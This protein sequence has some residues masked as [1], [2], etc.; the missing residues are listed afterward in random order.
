MLFRSF[1]P[2]PRTYQ[3]LHL[4][5]EGH[6][7]IQAYH[8]ALSDTPGTATLAIFDNNIGASRI[9][10]QA[11]DGD[12]QQNVEV[13]TVDAVTDGESDRVGLIKIDVEGHEHAV[14][15]GAG[16]LIQRDRPVIL[17]EQSRT[18]FVNGV[19][20]VIELLKQYGYSRFASVMPAPYMPA[21]I[22]AFARGVVTA[23]C[24]LIA[25]YS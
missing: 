9:A 16:R 14:L 19:S 2:N 23:V 11:D 21:W 3:L 4:N 25:G 10:R 6:S 13:K 20:P 12:R 7:N 22:P 24:R 8:C 18:D 1:E 15:K 17:L 5:T